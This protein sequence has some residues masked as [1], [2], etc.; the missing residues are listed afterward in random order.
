MLLVLFNKF[1][2]NKRSVDIWSTWWLVTRLSPN[3]ETTKVLMAIISFWFKSPSWSL[4]LLQ[5]QNSRLTWRPRL[6]RALIE[7]WKSLLR[8]DLAMFQR[9]LSL[10]AAILAKLFQQVTHRTQLSVLLGPL[11]LLLCYCFTCLFLT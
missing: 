6:S 4:L 10:C 7:G 5:T 3:L 1:S 8:V 11:L 2:W 9:R